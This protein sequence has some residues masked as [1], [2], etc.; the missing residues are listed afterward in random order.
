MEKWDVVI[1]GG[2]PAGS[3]CAARLQA[4]GL[5]VLVLDK[6]DFPRDKPCAGWITPQ[7]V[8]SLTLDVEEYRSGRVWQPIH[9]FRCG[10]IDGGCVD[11][12]YDQAVS[13]GIRRCEFDW[14][15]LRRS[16]VRAALGEPVT[17]LDCA[18]DGWVINGRYHARLLVGAGG[19]F[20]P[21]ARHLGVRRQHTGQVV[22][23]QEAEFVLAPRQREQVRV[24]P[25]VPELYFCPDLSGYGWCFLKGDVLNVGLGRFDPRELGAH[26]AR[27]RDFL[28]RRGRLDRQVGGQFKGHAYQVYDGVPPAVCGDRVLL[29]GD[30]AGLAYQQSGE[31]IRPA[32]ES[33]LMAAEMIVQAGGDYDHERL[34]A[35]QQRLLARFGGRRSPGIGSWLPASWVQR[36]AASLLA[37]RWFTRHVVMDRWFLHA[38]Q[39][40]LRPAPAGAQERQ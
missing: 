30:A 22:V 36:A 33:G 26:V 16:G 1:V 7:V 3:T 35:Y 13:Y 14:Y 19:H 27:F 6:N 28:H 25:E 10:L 21:V 2:G 24:N 4:A 37:T 5:S 31:G 11:T 32:V 38:R 40:A 9:G 29:I 39:P 34:L 20:C 8:Q 17:R 23:A 12:R 18:Q 15:L